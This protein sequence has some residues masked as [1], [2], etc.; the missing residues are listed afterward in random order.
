MNTRIHRAMRILGTNE[1]R[2]ANEPG[3]ANGPRIVNEP[4][5]QVANETRIG[6]TIQEHNELLRQVDDLRRLTSS[7]ECLA[8][9]AHVAHRLDRN[10]P[11]TFHEAMESSLRNQW[12]DSMHN[13]LESLHVNHLG[14]HKHTGIK[15]K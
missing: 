8:V 11:L 15:G 4:R 12:I 9:N 13:E 7:D 2:V 10:V 5:I 3:I 14:Y 6:V 1:P